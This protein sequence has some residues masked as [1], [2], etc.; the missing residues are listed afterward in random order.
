MIA[1]TRAV[2]SG[3]YGSSVYASDILDVFQCVADDSDDIILNGFGKFNALPK[4]VG[5]QPR[6]EQD[7][8]LK[9]IFKFYEISF[10]EAL[11]AFI[12]EF[13]LES[14]LR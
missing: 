8:R 4:Y 5:S 1:A 3:Q 13:D 11:A 14:S 10:K 6:P 2:L 7:R 12:V 9:E